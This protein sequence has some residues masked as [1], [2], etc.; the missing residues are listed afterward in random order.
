MFTHGKPPYP[1][2]G[3]PYQGS[4]IPYTTYDPGFHPMPNY[5]YIEPCVHDSYSHACYHDQHH[6]PMPHEFPTNGMMKGSAFIM[7]NYYPYLFDN[8][9]VRYGNM[10]NVSESVI[11]RI[12]QRTDPSCINLYGTFD[13]THGL[14]KNA[15]MT[16][17]LQKCISQKCGELQNALPIIQSPITFRLY[18][19][20]LDDMGGLVHQSAVT[21]STQDICFHFTDVRD[22]FVQSMKS[23]FYTNIPL[24]DYAG[25]YRLQL[26]KLKVYVNKI[27]TIDHLTDQGMNPFYAFQDNNN[28]IVLQHDVISNTQPDES[29]VLASIPI[30]QTIPFQQNLTTRLKLSFTAFLSDLI[31][32][33]Q[34][35]GIYNAMFEPT[36]VTL[37]M[38]KQ[39]LSTL[40]DSV[41]MINGTLAQMGEALNELRKTVVAHD[42]RIETN[43]NAIEELRTAVAS[44]EEELELRINDL[45]ARVTKLEAVPFATLKYKK[46][47]EFVKGQLTWVTYGQLYQVTKPFTA[48]GTIETEVSAGRLVP[49]TVD[50]DVFDN[51]NSVALEDI[52][53]RVETCEST[54]DE[55]KQKVDASVEQVETNTEDIVKC[56]ADLVIM[57]DQT[58]TLQTTIDQCVENIESVTDD[59][60]EINSDI[61]TMKTKL[62]TIDVQVIKND[63]KANQ[64]G[65]QTLHQSLEQV[66]ADVSDLT[67]TV[68]QTETEVTALQKQANDTDDVVTALQTQLNNTDANVVTLQTSVTDLTSEIH[69]LQQSLDEEI[70]KTN[71]MKT[72]LEDLEMKT[73]ENG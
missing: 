2:P 32:V 50:G 51:A 11:T 40:K 18:F 8:S 20:I 41:A 9:H 36:G 71:D 49:L 35:Y 33:P 61:K 63:I 59:V 1:P 53:T 70:V 55:C 28:R 45:E 66:S 44:D 17:H 27:N 30:G 67:Q 58:E 4:D 29:M 5:P 16:D 43:T 15:L 57:K 52:I 73:N 46:D 14:N 42:T 37:A 7:K 54:V 65:I 21:A 6:H 62:D 24:M 22:F 34:T 72:R 12:S 26:D 31:A 13:L 68:E 56:N 3:P 69:V 10:L 25:I 48:C 60:Q 19:S 23:I 64:N 38:V 47:K 39:E